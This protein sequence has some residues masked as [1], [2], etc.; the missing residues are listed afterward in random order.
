MELSV[1]HSLL[2]YLTK[3]VNLLFFTDILLTLSVGLNF[4]YNPRCL[5]RD[6]SPWFMS[7]TLNSSVVNWALKAP[8]FYEFDRRV[9]GGVTVADATYHSGGHKGIGGDIGEVRCDLLL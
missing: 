7:Q 1:S 3:N 4:T 9:E 8:T 2:L 5:T 6:F